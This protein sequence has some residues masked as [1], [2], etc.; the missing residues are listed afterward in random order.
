MF[1]RAYV[2][3]F[4]MLFSIF[5]FIFTQEV[6]ANEEEKSVVKQVI[7][8]EN[9]DVREYK[10]RVIYDENPNFSIESS[11]YNYKD[12]DGDKLLLVLALDFEDGFYTY[13][14]EYASYPTAFKVFGEKYEF[15]YP[16]VAKKFDLLSKKELKLYSDSPLYFILFEKSSNIF[17]KNE[18]DMQVSFLLCSSYN[19]TPFSKMFQMSIPKSEKLEDFSKSIYAN[20]FARSL[21][22]SFDNLEVKADKSVIQPSL[23]SKKLITQQ[24]VENT[25]NADYTFS[26]SPQISGSVLEATS[27]SLALILGLLAGF[28][29][30]FMPCVLPVVAIKIN[31]I[32]QSAHYNVEVQ[33]KMVRSHAIFF[34]FGILTLFVFLAILFGFFGMMWGSIFQN[35]YFIIFLISIIF[36]FALSFLNVFSLPMFNISTPKTSSH[37]IDSY[38]QGLVTTLIATPCSGPLLGSTLGFSLTLPLP[39]LILVFL[40]TGFGMALPYLIL[41]VFPHAIKL[42]PRSGKWTEIMEKVLAFLLLLTVLYLISILPSALVI[43]TLAYLLSSAFFLYIYSFFRYKKQAKI[44][45]LLLFIMHIALSAYIF[46]PESDKELVWQEYSYDEFKEELGTKNMIVDFTADWC[47]TCQVL[48]ETVLTYDN[49]KSLVDEYDI[50]LI[51]VDMTQYNE[52]NKDFLASL[53]SASIP[54]LALFRKDIFAYSPILLRDIYTFK[55]LKEEILQNF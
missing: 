5:A 43:K 28:I 20:D 34:S 9:A 19:C 29:L 42:I 54:L 10:N 21:S 40:A 13:D 6:R 15:Y 30:N 26:F 4:I 38:F 1:K 27:F 45:A 23:V 2:Y 49:L 22:L 25:E 24:S 39:L 31:S 55:Q 51:K 7:K 12:K 47:P 44:W 14:P 41:A 52:A 36:L 16:N 50:K 35:I 3:M 48:E 8:T 37:R 46:A 17:M 18:L 32:M 33:D 53:D 11:W